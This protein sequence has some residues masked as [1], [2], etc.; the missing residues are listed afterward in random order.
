MTLELLESIYFGIP[1]DDVRTVRIY[2]SLE[3]HLMTL[4][5]L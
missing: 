3:F 2:I 1:F 5:L 4:E